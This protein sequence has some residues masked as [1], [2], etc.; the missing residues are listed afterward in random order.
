ML[1]TLHLESQPSGSH[2][3][4]F[5]VPLP[6]IEEKEVPVS[7]SCQPSTTNALM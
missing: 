2:Q 3:E 6:G 4:D 1:S 7:T 5:L